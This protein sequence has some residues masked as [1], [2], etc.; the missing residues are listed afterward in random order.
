MDTFKVSK[1]QVKKKKQR[2]RKRSKEIK[3]SSD[4]YFFGN[5]S[6]SGIALNIIQMLEISS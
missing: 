3:F 6:D 2:L 1:S 4:F 5:I